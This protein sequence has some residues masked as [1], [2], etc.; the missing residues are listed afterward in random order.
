MTTT[1]TLASHWNEGG[2]VRC[3]TGHICCFYTEPTTV[4]KHNDLLSTTASNSPASETFMIESGSRLTEVDTT[5]CCK[6]GD[7]HTLEQVTDTLIDKTL[8]LRLVCERPL[9]SERRQ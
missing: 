5:H 3:Y 9:F 6:D 1:C 4:D 7:G 8:L 2:Y